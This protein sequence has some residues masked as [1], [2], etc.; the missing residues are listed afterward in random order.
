MS[1]NFRDGIEDEWFMVMLMFQLT[2]HFTDIVVKWVTH[3]SGIVRVVFIE[4]DQL[5]PVLL[6]L[7]CC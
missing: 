6:V 3:I 1:V 5:P 7:Q 2:Q 4:Y